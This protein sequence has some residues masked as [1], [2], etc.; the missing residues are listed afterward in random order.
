M[1]VPIRVIQMPGENHFGEVGGNSAVIIQTVTRPADTVQ[2][3]IGDLIAA[4]TVAASV[5]PITFPVARAI[6]R[7]VSIRRARLKKNNNSLTAAKFRLNLW[8]TNPSVSPGAI[9][10]G[11]NQALGVTESNYL[12]YFDFTMD[13]SFSDSAKGFAVPN[14][15]SEIITHPTSG[16]VNI[17]GL[18]EARDVYTPQSGEVFTAVLEVFRD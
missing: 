1:P 8:M 2:Y 3:A 11:D 13:K 4:T 6:D 17:F 18:L 15:G 7:P 16:T 12:G 9:T 5:I 10:S 14:V